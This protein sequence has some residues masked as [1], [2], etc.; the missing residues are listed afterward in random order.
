MQFEQELLPGTWVV[1]LKTFVDTR[2][3]FVKTYAR[4]AFDS[5]SIGFDMREEFYSIS[6]RDVVRGMHFQL[7]PHDHAK[8][9][10]C[11]AGAVEDV[12]L[13]LR[14]GASFGQV[15]RTE[16]RGDAPT[17]LLIPSGIAHGFL[18]L[19]DNTLMVYKTSS[20]HSPTH[21]AGI[22]WD[23]FGHEW[24]CPLPIVS[25]RD[26]AHAGFG[27]FKSPFKLGTK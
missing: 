11:A 7:P 22:R 9:V 14:E 17:L 5:Q 12:L 26:R 6:R 8:V 27:E 15:A 21:D 16:L 20:E 2:G 10:Y 18:S 3:T 24:S 23:S 19:T 1:R 4:T 13:D 25:E